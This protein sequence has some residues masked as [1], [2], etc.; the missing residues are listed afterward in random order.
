MSLQSML[1]LS[2]NVNKIKYF[3]KVAVVLLPPVAPHKQSQM[4]DLKEITGISLVISASRTS[5]YHFQNKAMCI[6]P[7]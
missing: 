4:N 7:S 2:K 3:V 1:W 6:K 5:V